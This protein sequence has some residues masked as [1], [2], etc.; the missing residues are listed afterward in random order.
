MGST[1]L[2]VGFYGHDLILYNRPILGRYIETNKLDIASVALLI[3][4]TCREL[5]RM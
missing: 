4:P 5:R 3:T 2:L 1:V